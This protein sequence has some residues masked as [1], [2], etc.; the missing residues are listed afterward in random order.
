MECKWSGSVPARLEFSHCGL[1]VEVSLAGCRIWCDST[2]VSSV[3]R[4]WLGLFA[5]FKNA[6][7]DAFNFPFYFWFHLFSYLTFRPPSLTRS[8]QCSGCVVCACVNICSCYKLTAMLWAF[9]AASLRCQ[10]ALRGRCGDT[11]VFPV[12]RLLARLLLEVSVGHIVSMR[13]ACGYVPAFRL[14]ARLRSPFRVSSC[15]WRRAL[16]RA[17]S[18]R[19]PVRCRWACPEPFLAWSVE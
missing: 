14:G 5:K 8:P 10:S 11:D 18:R 17:V 16:P 12:L 1:V 4:L 15:R 2:S 13:S 6:D 19:F 7:I 3:F 9:G